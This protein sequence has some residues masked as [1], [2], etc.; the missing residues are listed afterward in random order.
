MLVVWAYIWSNGI[1][2]SMLGIQSA[3]QW[4]SPVR[5]ERKQAEVVWLKEYK[6]RKGVK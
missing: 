1:L 3:V 5:L 2:L 6:Q 4:F